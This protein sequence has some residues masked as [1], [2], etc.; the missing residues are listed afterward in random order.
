MTRETTRFQWSIFYLCIQYKALGKSDDNILKSFPRGFAL[1]S[2]KGNPCAFMAA[3][4]FAKVG[5]VFSCKRNRAV[6][7]C[8]L[9]CAAHQEARGNHLF[10]PLAEIGRAHV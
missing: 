7:Q 1:E 4:R 2:F 8:D 3:N 6:P 10:N 5:N 9:V